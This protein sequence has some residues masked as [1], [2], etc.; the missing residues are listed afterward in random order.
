MKKCS[1][2]RILLSRSKARIPKYFA[3]GNIKENAPTAPTFKH[4]PSTNYPQL[5]QI[6][7]RNISGTLA[8]PSSPKMTKEA[9]KIK[10]IL[11]KRPSLKSDYVTM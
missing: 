4:R 5:P 2:A 1:T 10:A 6:M 7:R 11:K 9:K 8:I 3:K